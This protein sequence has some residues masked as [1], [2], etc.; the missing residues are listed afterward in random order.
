MEEGQNH[1]VIEPSE[2]DIKKAINELKT[3]KSA[4]ENGISAEIIKK[5]EVN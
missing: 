1:I 4:G 2:T 3:S 5:K